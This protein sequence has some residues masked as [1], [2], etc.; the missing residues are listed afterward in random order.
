MDNELLGVKLEH[1]WKA[2]INEKTGKRFRVA[3]IKARTTEQGSPVSSASWYKMLKG[4]HRP[5]VDKVVALARLFDVS[6][7]YL[8][9]DSIGLSDQP[10]SYQVAEIKARARE[11]SREELQ[12]T[13]IG[14][15]SLLNEQVSS[16]LG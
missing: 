2:S 4:L 16:Q 5:S 3:E 11:M 12:Q 10:D 1:S 7:D 15:Q 6:L 13:I 8:L 9:N 14:L